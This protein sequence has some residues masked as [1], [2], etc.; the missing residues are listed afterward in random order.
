MLVTSEP[1]VVDPVVNE[2]L[3]S[4]VYM[5]EHLSLDSKPV[6]HAQ[7]LLSNM[8]LHFEANMRSSCC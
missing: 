7:E 4:D 8:P 1:E 2:T 3:Y 5:P 6:Y